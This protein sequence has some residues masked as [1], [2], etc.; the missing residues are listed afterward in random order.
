[1]LKNV[2]PVVISSQCFHW[3]KQSRSLFVMLMLQKFNIWKR[4]GERKYNTWKLNKLNYQPILLFVGFF[5][6]R[7]MMISQKDHYGVQ[8]I[9]LFIIDLFIQLLLIAGSIYIHNQRYDILS[10]WFLLRGSVHIGIKFWR[11]KLISLHY[12]FV[13][14]T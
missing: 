12:I 7:M 4:K 3:D 8:I 1:M 14:L 13:I 11:K 6:C 2:C 5:M 10:R 9:K